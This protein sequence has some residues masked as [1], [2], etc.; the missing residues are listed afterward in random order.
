MEKNSNNLLILVVDDDKDLREIVAIKLKQAGF[1]IEEAENGEIAVVKA[2]KFKPDLILMDVQMPKMNG[3][4][5]LAKIKAD[6]ETSAIK[7]IFLTNYGEQSA[8]DQPLDDRF[9]KDIGA[10]G[11]IRKTDDLDKIVERVKKELSIS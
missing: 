5:S 6:P 1:R 11:H 3:I 2:K 4:E 8:T 10:L 7:V 9:A